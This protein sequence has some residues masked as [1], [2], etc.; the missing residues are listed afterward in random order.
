MKKS[1]LITSFIALLAFGA[2]KDDEPA[3]D[4][5]VGDWELDDV[6]LKFNTSGYSYFE[7]EGDNDLYG[8]SSY[9][10][11]F[12][13]DMT[14]EREINDIPEFGN[15]NDEGV[16][17]MDGDEIDLDS[18]DNEINGIPYSFTLLELD[19]EELLVE[20][21]S[22]EI[23]W[24]DTQIDAWRADGTLLADGTFNVSTQEEFDSLRNFRDVVDAT[25]TLK[26][27]RD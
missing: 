27:E 26:F 4:P 15:V 5:I 8:E 22:Q 24:S 17:E 12:S 23:V 1:L 7:F 10:L 2:C 19:D 20:Y 21:E 9:T 18:D 25:L 11:E 16:W 14:Y 3:I 13:A 6:S